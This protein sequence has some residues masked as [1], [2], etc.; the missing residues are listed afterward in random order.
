MQQLAGEHRNLSERL[1]PRAIGQP[2]RRRTPAQLEKQHAAV[3]AELHAAADEHRRAAVALAEARQRLRETEDAAGRARR[4]AAA[5]VGREAGQ[6][7]QARQQRQ[8]RSGRHQDRA[9]QERTAARPPPLATEPARTRPAG[10]RPGHGRRPLATGSLPRTCAAMPSGTSC[11]PNRR[12][13]SCTSARNRWP[14]TRSARCSSATGGG[15]AKRE[16]AGEAQ[17]ARARIRKLE[18]KLHAK[19]LAA[20]EVRHERTTLA[21]RLR[22][23]YGIE[24]AELEHEPTGRRAARSARRSSRKSPSCAA[25]STTSAT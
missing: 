14:P 1:S 10:T 21:D 22:E 15:S 12:W 11:T 8:P 18:E 25:S 4:P 20:G 23:D 9:G 13:P 5:R 3:E 24:L 16:L 2:R 6:L 17:R 19:E 7:E